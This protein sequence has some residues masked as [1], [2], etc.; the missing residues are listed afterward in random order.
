MDYSS[1]EMGELGVEEEQEVQEVQE[2]HQVE[3]LQ[4]VAS[5]LQQ[6][7]QPIAATQRSA[8]T[9]TPVRSVQQQQPQSGRLRIDSEDDNEEEE[10]EYMD[11]AAVGF[12]VLRSWVQAGVD[13]N[14][15]CGLC[16]LS[17]A[18]SF[19]KGGID[20]PCTEENEEP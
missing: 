8:V 13:G 16:S 7:Q 11:M 14:L 19:A 17:R 9:A 3:Q 2:E 6:Q 10:D 1:Q 18:D 12:S 20:G 4:E 5:S 15:N